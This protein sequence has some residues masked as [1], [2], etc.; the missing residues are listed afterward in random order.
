M[1]EGRGA[2][3]ILIGKLTGKRPLERPMNRWDENNR[4]FLEEISAN[5]RNC[6]DAAE[7]RDNWGALVNV[8]LN[9]RVP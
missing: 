2:F 5:G 1:E 9:P 8:N 4:I 3:S 7:D 6:N